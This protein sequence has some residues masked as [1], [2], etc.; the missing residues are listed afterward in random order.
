MHPAA[1]RPL[2]VVARRWD[3]PRLR[4]LI[5]PSRPISSFAGAGHRVA[6]MF[7]CW[8]RRDPGRVFVDL[9]AGR[10]PER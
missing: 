2:A 9:T 3:E 7:R 6:L 4:L 5:D 8:R 1:G 10:E